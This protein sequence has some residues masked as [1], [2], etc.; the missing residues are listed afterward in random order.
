[1]GTKELGGIG[2]CVANVDVGGV[3]DP[4]DASKAGKGYCHGSSTEDAILG[5]EFEP[6]GVSRN[7]DEAFLS[8]SGGGFKRDFKLGSCCAFGVDREIVRELSD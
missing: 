3:T 8:D 2:V 5:R 1:M 7:G 4:A 6:C